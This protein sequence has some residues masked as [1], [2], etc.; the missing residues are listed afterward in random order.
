MGPSAGAGKRYDGME[1]RF[2]S[3]WKVC[4]LFFGGSSVCLW[5]GCGGVVGF[6]VF[7]EPQQDASLRAIVTPSL[8]H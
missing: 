5:M 6:V 8:H 7:I 4:G 2:I 1:W 3:V